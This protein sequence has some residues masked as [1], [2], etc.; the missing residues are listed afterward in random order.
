MIL[1]WFI[2]LNFSSNEIGA[3]FAFTI[4]CVAACIVSC[5][6]KRPPPSGIARV[7]IALGWYTQVFESFVHLVNNSGRDVVLPG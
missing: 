5:P 6:G 4:C 1:V 3:I 7:H 2:S